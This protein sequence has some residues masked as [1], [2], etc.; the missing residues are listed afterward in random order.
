MRVQNQRLAGFETAHFDSELTISALIC[1]YPQN[2]NRIDTCFMPIL[3]HNELVPWGQGTGVYV[4]DNVVQFPK[5]NWR[6]VRRNARA[7]KPATLFMQVKR[8][9]LIAHLAQPQLPI[10]RVSSRIHGK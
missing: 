6:E 9:V 10:R 1:S 8:A 3:G 4:M 5:T 2:I 7:A